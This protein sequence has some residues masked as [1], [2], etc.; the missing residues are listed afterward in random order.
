MPLETTSSQRVRR[1]L[2]GAALAW[3]GLLVVAAI[4]I[5]VPFCPSPLLAFSPPALAIGALLGLAVTALA[6]WGPLRA[7]L[8]AVSVGWAGVAAL[9]LTQGV[10][11]VLGDE[12]VWL[13]GRSDPRFAEIN[14]PGS[15][16]YHLR[17]G[18]FAVRYTFDDEGFRRVPPPA[19]RQG[20][21][22]EAPRPVVLV[23]GCSFTFGLGVADDATY[24]AQLQRAWPD[25]RL[26]LRARPGW[27]TTQAV[28]A[29]DDWLEK[30]PP[31][32]AVAYGW[33]DHHSQ[34]NWR[35]RSFHGQRA[36][37]LGGTPFPCFELRGGQLV[38][39]GL[40]PPQRATA[41][42]DGATVEQETRLSVALLGR[43]AERCRER[44]IP[45]WVW[46][47]VAP[48]SGPHPALA[49]AEAAGVEVFHLGGVSNDYFPRDR[50]PRPGWHRAMAAAIA[51]DGRTQFLHVRRGTEA[52]R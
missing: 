12:V 31:P 47:L 1:V 9:F 36:Q 4:S 44:G 49:A 17:R 29:L 7:A 23:L 45:F 48:D 28:L 32:A 14:W 50:H 38:Y 25:Y 22:A 3:T 30:Q 40:L 8:V 10:S 43:L 46:E 2:Q 13:P 35:R 41:P 19:T 24:A 16:G 39:A 15:L 51:A 27:G 42:D 33:I 20:D 34:R 5:R 37:P 52:T 21:E 11:W 26:V 6:R 18:E